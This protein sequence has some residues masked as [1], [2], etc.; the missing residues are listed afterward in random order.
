MGPLRG[1]GVVD[2]G[3]PT[4]NAT[5]TVGPLAGANRD[6]GSPTINVKNV[7]GASLAGANRDPRAP[8]INIKNINDGLPRRCWSCR[9]GST[10]H[11]CKKR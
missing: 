2:L 5:S 10:H 8:T 11:Q 1:A 4:V 9:I 6:P 7:D 3:A